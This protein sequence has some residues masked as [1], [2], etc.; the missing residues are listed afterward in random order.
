MRR[1]S[2]SARKR[3][4]RSGA[5]SSTLSFLDRHEVSL[6]RPGKD[7]S[8]PRDL[9]IGILDHLLPLREPAG[10]AWDGEHHGEHLHWD[11]E[12]L[13]DQAG[14]EVDVRV[15]LTLDEVF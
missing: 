7:L 3:R 5:A 15:E 8:R 4:M 14:V 2:G 13:V 10:D 12:R 9:L 1:L 6:P 11:V